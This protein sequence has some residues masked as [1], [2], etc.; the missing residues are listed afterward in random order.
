MLWWGSILYAGYRT[1][2]EHT[3]FPMGIG[4]QVL[5]VPF[6]SVPERSENR[7]KWNFQNFVQNLAI[8]TSVV[9]YTAKLVSSCNA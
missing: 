7:S 1:R 5:P 6:C 9:E 4:H 3:N 2:D 8:M